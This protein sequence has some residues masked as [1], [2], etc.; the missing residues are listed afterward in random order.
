MAKENKEQSSVMEDEEFIEF[1]ENKFGKN[2]EGFEKVEEKFEKVEE[3][4]EKVEE[5]FER[6]DERLNRIENQM[7]TKD[8]L[9]DKIE[10]LRGDLILKLKKEDEKFNLLVE[11]L[12]DKK[13]VSKKDV[14]RIDAIAVFPNLK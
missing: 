2:E 4:F 11:V 8:Y 14:A 1:L 5:R 13:V 9:D 7:V 10:D 12:L 3:R 6:V